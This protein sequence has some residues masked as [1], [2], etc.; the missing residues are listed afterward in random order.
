VSAATA[1]AI[2][3]V[4]AGSTTSRAELSST[5]FPVVASSTETATCAPSAL[6]VRAVARARAN[7]D[8]VGTAPLVAPAGN[9]GP[10]EISGDGA[11]SGSTLAT[12]SRR[13]TAAAVPATR[14]AAA[15]VAMT[16]VRPARTAR[17]SIQPTT[18][19]T[20]H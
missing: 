12:S 15:V 4:D 13:T 5:G 11:A 17:T 1:V 8:A 18:R 20:G 19:R 14:T 9:N 2:F 16:V 3:A 6:S 7:P 10:R